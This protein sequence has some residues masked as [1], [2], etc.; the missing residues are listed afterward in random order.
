V[1]E[2]ALQLIWRH[3]L[4]ALNLLVALFL[5][6]PFVAPALL[7]A[8]QPELANLIYA[9][10]QLTC[11][12]WPFRAYFLFGPQATYSIAELQ[13]GGVSAIYD[14]RGSPEFGY[15]V[16]FCA[17]NVAIYAAVLAAGLTYAHRRREWTP[18][19]F[20]AYSMAIVPMALDGLTQLFGWRES[21]W[22]LRTVT[23]LL[24]GAASVWLLYPRLDRAIAT[25]SRTNGRTMPRAAA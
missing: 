7:R 3:W 14:F 12:Q 11:H 21:S 9:A 25:L 8:G 20:G 6:L 23:G 15:E 10:Y 18:L 4:L 22:E 16:A 5:A 13:A 24:F 19:S 2:T 1:K 17:R